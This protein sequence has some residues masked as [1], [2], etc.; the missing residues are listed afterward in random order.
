M[1]AVRL[2]STRH[3]RG[4]E[5]FFIAASSPFSCACTVSRA[6][7]ATR[8][9]KGPSPASERV[10]KVS[11]LTVRLCGQCVL[12]STGMSCPMNCPK[13]PSQWSLRWR[14][15]GWPLRSQT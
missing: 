2:W 12:S 5:T 13:E 6:R 9:S 14:A 4:L 8:A 3:A 10:V 1:Y 15:R 11:C 7:S